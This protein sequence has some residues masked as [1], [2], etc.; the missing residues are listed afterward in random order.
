M[1]LIVVSLTFYTQKSGKVTAISKKSCIFAEKL[2][3]YEIQTMP[4]CNSHASFL[5]CERPAETGI[6]GW[7]L[8]L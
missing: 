8:S 7:D 4:F 3:E 6:L 5:R 2:F 1:L